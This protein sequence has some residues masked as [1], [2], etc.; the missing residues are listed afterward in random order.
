MWIREIK[1]MK[2]SGSKKNNKTTGD[3][4]ETLAAEYLENNGYMISEKNYRAGK[5]GEID[6]IAEK[7]SFYVY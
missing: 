5:I 3:L 2:I 6:I 1:G 7:K 4:G